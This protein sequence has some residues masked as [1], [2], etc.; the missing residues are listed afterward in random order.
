[1]LEALPDQFRL[2][3]PLDR[4]DRERETTV[5]R[6]GVIS[7]QLRTTFC[8][9][10]NVSETGVQVKLY[11]PLTPGED[12]ILRVGDNE[13]VSGKIVWIKD[14]NAGL[15]LDNP[16]SAIG[17]MRMRDHLDNK[18]RRSTPRV[19]TS[20]R[21]IVRSG[22]R[23]VGAQLHNISSVG[24]KLSAGR[25]LPMGVQ[26]KLSL[27]D[28][29]ELGAFVCWSENDSFGVRFK[30][31]LSVDQLAGWLA[32]RNRV[33]DDVGDCVVLDAPPAVGVPTAQFYSNPPM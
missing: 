22:G 18:R 2:A 1:M 28:L 31:P 14:R 33:A 21:A 7:S 11:D 3:A 16:L 26:L 29:P 30:A 6:I 15:R 5:L 27:P 17:L 25:S 4:R 24:A 20:A 19:R 8:V 10:R 32:S 12:V 9:L 23:V 13:A